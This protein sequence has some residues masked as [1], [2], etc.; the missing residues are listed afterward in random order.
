MALVCSQHVNALGS[1]AVPRWVADTATVSMHQMSN[2]Y[3]WAVSQRFVV[4]FPV[5]A[6]YAAVLWLLIAAARRRI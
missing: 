4:V 5:T 3:I 1:S 2:M 6:S